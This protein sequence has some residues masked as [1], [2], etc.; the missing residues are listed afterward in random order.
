[1]LDRFDAGAGARRGSGPLASL[2]RRA[3][4]LGE[5]LGEEHD[6]V[7]LAGRIRSDKALGGRARKVLLK[8]IARRRSRLQRQALRRGERL[9]RR[10]TRSFLALLRRR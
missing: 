9:Y 8:L 4:E 3:D 1:M 2:A 6:L 5:L 10:R 7:L